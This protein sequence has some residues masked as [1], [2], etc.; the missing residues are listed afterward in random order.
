MK[1]PKVGGSKECFRIVKTGHD[2][3]VTLLAMSDR[4]T[5]TNQTGA[6]IL[7]RKFDVCNPESALSEA[8]N[9]QLLLGDGLINIPA[10]SNDPACSDDALC[11]IGGLCDYIENEFVKISKSSRETMSE[12][13][14]LAKVAKHQRSSA[15]R[16]LSM[17]GQ[18]SDGHD[19]DDDIENDDDDCMEVDF[20]AMLVEWNKTTVEP[21]GW[22][23][24]YLLLNHAMLSLPHRLVSFP[25]AE[26]L[27]D[28]ILLFQRF[29]HLPL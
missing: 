5:T 9:A 26:L 23:Y 16:R 8:R 15:R 6:E 21:F 28:P 27:L 22:R 7:A 4:N 25:T 20:Q 13:D 10:Q 11:N 2:Q 1:Y 19:I 17:H 12:L 29:F 18:E 24:V 14:V 3:A